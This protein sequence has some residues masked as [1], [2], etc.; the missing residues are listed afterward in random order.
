[1]LNYE[2]LY[3]SVLP[4]EK[5][6]KDSAGTVA[7]LQKAIQ[8]NT[9]TGNL[10]EV[11]KS[12]TALYEAVALLKELADALDAEVN[13]FN[14]DEYFR[15]GDFTKQLLESCSQK[16][17]DV[18]GEKGVYEMFPYK[19]RVIGDEEHAAEVYINRKKVPSFRPSFV[20]ETIRADREKLFRANF[21]AQS[22]MTE[23]AEAYETAC[24]KSNV[25]IGST[26]KL[27][28]VYKTMVPMARARKEYDKQAFAFDLA[29]LYEAGT[30]AWIT[31]GGK[32]YYFGTSR[33]GKSGFR[34]LSRSGVESFINTMKPV[35]EDTED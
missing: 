23:L 22:F 4:L 1:M 24:L 10:N 15:S 29:R 30:D 14:S 19:V 16:N 18:R 2:D 20:A 25:R 11:K 26:Q 34:V 12:L 13:A 5:A 8:K 6:L 33:D 28:K 9:E 3:E 7:R 31:K 32:Q 21:N 17:V 35:A 27:D